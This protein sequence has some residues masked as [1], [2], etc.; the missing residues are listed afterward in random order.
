MLT[1]EQRNV[2]FGKVG[3][4][5]T[6]GQEEIHSSEARVRLVAGGE[7]SGKSK[8]AAQDLTARLFFGK[9][10]WLVAADYE[11]T[12]AEFDYICENLEKLGVKYIATKQ[13]DPGQIEIEGGI[14]I[15]TKSAKDPRKLAME[16]P[17]GIVVC[18]ASQIDYETYLRLTGRLAEK[19]GWMLLSGTFE[20]SLGWYVEAYERGRGAND[21][22]LVSF[23]LPTWTNIHIFPQGRED[24]EIKRLEAMY[25][26]EWFMERFGG[27][28][29][30]P[31]GL[32]FN[33]FRNHLH[34]GAGKEYEFAPTEL[35]YIFVDPGYASAYS[36][37]VAQKRGD[38]L[39]II[40]EVYERGL[41]TSDIIKICKQRP[42]WNK[43]IGGA[44]DIA[45]TQH[46]A[47]SAPT[48]TWMK[49]AG[50]ILRS[51]KIRI[52]DGIEA[53]KRFLII[54]PV[55]GQPLL[56]INSKAKGLISE[57]GGCNNPIDGQVKPYKWRVDSNGNVIGDTPEDKDNH[58]SKALAY[59]IVDLFGFAKSGLNKTAKVKYF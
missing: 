18:E 17:D 45:G 2:I 21:E 53:V 11:R 14:R 40:D 22:G 37:E 13:V 31:T 27:V 10:W 44:I 49:E 42:W 26:K 29:T 9:L 15:V 46:Q 57:F 12:R 52:Q 28:P 25:S 55:T 41:I 47:M 35:C 30:P 48:E 36:V 4:F 39:Y 8:S 5:P 33:E 50:I 54:N 32:V 24:R 19:R 20:S 51:K 1:K 38:S 58:A 56:H 23:S 43:V 6:E 59:G 7:R 16:A 34:V 3:Y